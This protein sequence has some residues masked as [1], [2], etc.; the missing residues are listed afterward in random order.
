VQ[1]RPF[2]EIRSERLRA[3]LYDGVYVQ[4]IEPG[5]PSCADCQRYVYDDN[6]EQRKWRGAPMERR[7]KDTPCHKCPKSRDKKTPNPNAEL[8]AG[9]WR[10]YEYW[11]ASRS[12]LQLPAD[13]TTRACFSLIQLAHDRAQRRQTDLLQAF[14]KVAARTR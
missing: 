10:C 1:R 14:L 11:L 6:W 5:L 3:N 12:G 13:G 2:R 9:N 7:D 4:L 8:T